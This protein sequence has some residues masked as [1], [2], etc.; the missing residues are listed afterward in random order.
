MNH[1]D[2]EARVSDR[3]PGTLNVIPNPRSFT[4]VPKDEETAKPSCGS[5]QEPGNK[6]QPFADASDFVIL[7]AFRASPYH[8][9]R[10]QSPEDSIRTPNLT[11]QASRVLS[12]SRNAVDH[13]I[14]NGGKWIPQHEEFVSERTMPL[15]TELKLL[16]RSGGKD[17]VLRQCYEFKPISIPRLSSGLAEDC[18]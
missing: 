11:T 6:Q 7:L 16:A 17:A 1:T 13:D 10:P 4:K 12:A 8:V 9:T 3:L 14:S 18:T 15:G 5:P 2:R